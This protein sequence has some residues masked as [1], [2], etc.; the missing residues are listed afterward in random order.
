MVKYKFG[1]KSCWYHFGL[2]QGPYKKY[3][4]T[5]QAINPLPP[6]VHFIASV[7]WL[8]PPFTPVW[9]CTLYKAP[10]HWLNSLWNIFQLTRPTKYWQFWGLNFHCFHVVP[11]TRNKPT[12]YFGVKSTIIRYFKDIASWYYV[13]AS[14]DR[15]IFRNGEKL[16]LFASFSMLGM[17]VE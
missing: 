15:T 10:Y 6:T 1:H 8:T 17:S 5:L 16:S 12:W 13:S 7:I 11:H 14:C 2:Y 3:N 9:L 4:C